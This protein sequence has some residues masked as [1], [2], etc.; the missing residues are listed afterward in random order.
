[1]ANNMNH[2]LSENELAKAYNIINALLQTSNLRSKTKHYYE[3]S[4]E[5]I[6]PCLNLDTYIT[7]FSQKTIVANSTV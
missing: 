4:A 2:A 7:V 5:P 3:V 1:M 6:L